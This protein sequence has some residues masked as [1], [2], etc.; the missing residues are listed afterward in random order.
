MIEVI[1]TVKSEIE[2]LRPLVEEYHRLENLLAFLEGPNK[3]IS[4]INNTDVINKKGNHGAIEIMVDSSFPEE[5]RKRYNIKVGDKFNS[6]TELARLI[7]VPHATVDRWKHRDGWI[8]D[9]RKFKREYTKNSA[10]RI[11]DIMNE[12]L[13]VKYAVQPG[14][15]WH[16]P[17]DMMEKLGISQ[18]TVHNW[19]T[20]GYIEFFEI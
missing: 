11:S 12:R 10:V 6:V 15:F 7:G 9:G 8:K 16:N 20:K 3:D 19:K 2:R 13:K 1:K 4:S 14:D 17:E 5:L 18:P